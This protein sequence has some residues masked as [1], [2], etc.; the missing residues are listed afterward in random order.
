MKRPL[1][2]ICA[3][4]ALILAFGLGWRVMPG[5]WPELKRAV[6]G[7][8][9]TTPAPAQEPLYVPKSNTAF[10]EA[11]G[12]K[13]SLIY[14]FYK[15]YCP[16]CRQL[17]PL[18]GGLPETITLPD[19]TP[20]RVRLVCLNKVEEE[21]ARVIAEYYTAHAVPEERQYVP[22]VVIGER[23]LFTGSEIIAQL[24]EALTA[25]EGVNT[26]LLNGTERAAAQ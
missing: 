26:P 21:P 16:Y 25:G 15:D 1:K 24:L 5:V 11:I 20:S 23:Y 2:I 9:V 18:M 7:Q 6:L 19:G 17:D 14:Y 13:D 22:A 12:E 3:A 10:E 8:P 4:L